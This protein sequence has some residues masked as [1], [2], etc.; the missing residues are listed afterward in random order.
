MQNFDNINCIKNYI[1][2]EYNKFNDFNKY[3]INKN[4]KKI[5][6]NNKKRNKNKI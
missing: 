4:N 3:K 2:D 1:Q 5:N 6:K